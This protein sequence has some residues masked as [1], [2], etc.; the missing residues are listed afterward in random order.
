MLH[1]FNMATSK[2]VLARTDLIDVTSCNSGIPCSVAML[3]SMHDTGERQVLRD[4]LSYNWVLLELFKGPIDN[5]FEVTLTAVDSVID[6]KLIF[7][8]IVI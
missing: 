2:L 3:A 4:K 8:M 6:F 1:V 7:V 5:Q